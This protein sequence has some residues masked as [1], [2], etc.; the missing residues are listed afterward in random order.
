MDAQPS[1]RVAANRLRA[2][3]TLIPLNA[4]PNAAAN[5][6]T[7]APG[8]LRSNWPIERKIASGTSNSQWNGTAKTGA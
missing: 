3:L 6:P 2:V 8:S 5:S 7:I 1:L 4:A